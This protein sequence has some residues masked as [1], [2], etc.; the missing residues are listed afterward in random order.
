MEHSF[1]IEIAKAYGVHEAILLKNI[2]FWVQ[3]NIA[4][5]KNFYDGN[6][7]TYNSKTA[8][9]QLFPYLTQR[10][11]GYALNHLIAAG[12]IITGNYNKD[13]RD[14]TLWYAIT[15]KGYKLLCCQMQMTN[16]S[17][18]NDKNVKPLP[19]ITDTDTKENN[20]K[21][22][23]KERV[24][25]R[26]VKPT[27]KEVQDYCES[28]KNGIDAGKFIDFYESKGWVVGK[29]P[30]KDW[31]AAVRTWER[32]RNN[33]KSISNSQPAQTPVQSDRTLDVKSYT[34]GEI[35]S[36]LEQDEQ[37][38]KLRVEYSRQ[39]MELAKAQLNNADS[40]TLEICEEKASKALETLNARIRKLGF[41]PREVQ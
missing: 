3:K 1:D 36:V 13:G 27:L 28:R 6:W 16:L 4:N 25:K 35:L 8:W 31:K 24:I 32:Q 41:D 20:I 22:I 21:D 7:W 34:R 19:D 11:I 40:V 2:F 39:S 12:I 17:N 23:A 15:E 26:F 18:A 9:E 38:R 14:R 30:M 5:D 33:E 37:Y 29:S 10:Q